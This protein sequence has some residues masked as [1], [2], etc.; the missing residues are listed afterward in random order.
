MSKPMTR[1]SLSDQTEADRVLKT[2]MDG[3]D[4]LTTD[5]EYCGQVYRKTHSRGTLF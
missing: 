5:V 3:S 1:N 2:I 4:I